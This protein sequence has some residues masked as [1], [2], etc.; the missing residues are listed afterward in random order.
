MI[1]KDLLKMIGPNKKYIFVIVALMLLGTIAN[2]AITVA[3]CWAI[4]IVITQPNNFAGY[5]APACIAFSAIIVRFITSYLSG[6]LKDLL[7]RNVK[8][9]LREK[10]YHKILQLGTRSTQEMSM[11]GL[12]QVSL[13]GIEQL[14]LYFSVY[15]PQF[16]FSMLVP[17]ILFIICIFIN[18]YVALALLL[19]VPLIPVSIVMISKYA[20]RVFAKYWGKYTSMGDSFLDSVQG[21]TELKVNQADELYN[22][23]MNKKAE[24]FRVI[25]MKVLVMQL[26][27]TTIM[28]LVAYAGAGLGIL[29]TLFGL[30]KG[31]PLLVSTLKEVSPIALAL[32]LVLVAVEF[33]LPLRT[34]GS[35]FHLAM[36][37]LSAGRKIINLLQVE[38]PKWGKEEVQHSSLKVENL[39]FSYDGKRNAL[40]NV[41][42]Q[43]ASNGMTAIVGESGCGKTTIVNLLLGAIHA[44]KGH[45]YIGDT[46][47]E[48]VSRKSY[49]NKLAV[50]SYNT[51]I[52]HDS[53]RKNFELAKPNITDEEIYLAL[54]KVNL[55]NYV[56]ENGG[57]D[58][59]LQED[60]T[61][62]SGGQK[63]RLALAIN[64]VVPKDIYIFD[65]ATSN[66]D[67]DSEA[68]ILKNMHELAKEKNVIIISHRLANVV[69]ANTIYYME[70]GNILERGSHMELIQ[71]NGGYAAL[72]ARQ[73]QLEEGYKGTT[74]GGNFYA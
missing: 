55:Y 8:K 25:T 44:N 43:F 22:I 74:E 38:E 15:L 6:R 19:S 47:L 69:D 21:L 14:D 68:I 33:F 32:F 7:G 31:M 39:T 67:I 18:W 52:F 28:D 24:E 50:I 12:T 34:L 45:I 51:F 42:M 3:I 62:I 48:E 17:L 64:L 40:N 49:Y 20:K 66:I 70:S 9:E 10:V 4:H 61:N 54:K 72:F 60:A 53:I 35:A 16:F 36:N 71:A 29:L 5:I 23:E 65:E 56:V 30:E 46:L 63:Q 26:A 41:N 37:G 73:K 59:Q 57:L 58:K 2:L 13:E 27:S 11:A 1:D